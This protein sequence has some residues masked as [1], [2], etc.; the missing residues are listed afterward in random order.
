[1]FW[2]MVRSCLV[3]VGLK[4]DLMLNFVFIMVW[5]ILIFCLV[6]VLVWFGVG[7]VLV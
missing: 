7:L 2:W 3:L 1:M 6:I 5:L 4:Y